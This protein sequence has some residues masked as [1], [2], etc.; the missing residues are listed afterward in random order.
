[1]LKILFFEKFHVS[2]GSSE[3][4][5]WYCSHKSNSE[6][7]FSIGGASVFSSLEADEVVRRPGFIWCSLIPD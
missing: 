1:M 5:V 6:T 3:G 4:E 2:S 7:L